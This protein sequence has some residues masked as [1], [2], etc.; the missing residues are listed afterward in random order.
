MPGPPTCKR[1]SQH[2]NKGPAAARA[3]LTGSGYKSLPRAPHN[4]FHTSTS[5]SGICKLLM[6]GHLG[7]GP[8]R[9]STRSSVQDLC[10]I[11]WGSLLERNFAGSPQEPTYARIYH[12]NSSD[13]RLRTPLPTV[14]ASLR[15]Q[16][17]HG[18]LTRAILHENFQEKCRGPEPRPT[19]CA[20]LRSRNAH[21]HVTRTILCENL[22]ENCRGPR[23][24]IKKKSRRRLCEPPQSKCTWTCHKSHFMGEFTGV[25]WRQEPLSV[26]TLFGEQRKRKLGSFRI[27][28]FQTLCLQAT[29]ILCWNHV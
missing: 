23:S 6:Q 27:Y 28:G 20:S 17:A 4:S 10:K 19:F 26:D 22:Q 29:A 8:T 13:Q 12:E 24:K 9:I 16:N 11:M 25:P 14:C 3:D 7:E 2:R 18:H 15:S 5:K 21:G 1:I